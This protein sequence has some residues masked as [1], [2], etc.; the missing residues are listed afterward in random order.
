MDVGRTGHPTI[1]A[2]TPVTF[3]GYLKEKLFTRKTASIVE[4]SAL[5]VEM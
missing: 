4:L 3:W 2:L 5:L 1:Q